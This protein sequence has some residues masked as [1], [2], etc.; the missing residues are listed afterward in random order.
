MIRGTL[1]AL[2]TAAVL[3]S[4]GGTDNGG[5]SGDG[6]AVDCLDVPSEVSAA[7]MTG[8]EG[9]KLTAGDAAAVKSPDHKQL[10]VVAV[11]FTAD[12]LDGDQTGVWGAST[13]DGDGPFLAVDGFAQEFTTW[14]DA[15]KSPAKLGA[16]DPLVKDATSCL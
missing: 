16:A 15:G 4:C 5:D 7:L 9:A 2:T 12:G 8:N 6:D 3:T 10:Y 14:P 11:R 13:L 1:L